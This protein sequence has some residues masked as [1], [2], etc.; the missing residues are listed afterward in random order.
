M[1]LNGLIFKPPSKLGEYIK[2][3]LICRPHLRKRCKD[4]K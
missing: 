4:R 3:L 1:H 2:Q